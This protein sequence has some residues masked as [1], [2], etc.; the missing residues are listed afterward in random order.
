M[1]LVYA[2][3]RESGLLRDFYSKIFTEI[4]MLDKKVVV[5]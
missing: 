5:V 1:N 4:E 2:L 3:E